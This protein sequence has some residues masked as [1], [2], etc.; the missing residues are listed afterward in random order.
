MNR[1]NFTYMGKGQGIGL[2]HVGAKLYVLLWHLYISSACHQ[3][4]GIT[5]IHSH[6]NLDID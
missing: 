3:L 6:L 1:H 4:G 5:I 2:A